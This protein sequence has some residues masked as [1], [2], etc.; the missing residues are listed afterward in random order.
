MEE[1]QHLPEAGTFKMVAG[2]LHLS[3]NVIHILSNTVVFYCKTKCFLTS[4][5]T[6][7]WPSVF[8]KI[9]IIR[10]LWSVSEEEIFFP[11]L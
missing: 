7:F 5:F 11:G 2:L 1:Y 3:F 6:G 10:V 4:V 9:K 8:S